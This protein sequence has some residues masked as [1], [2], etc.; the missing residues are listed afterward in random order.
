MQAEALEDAVDLVVGTPQRV[1]QLAERGALYYGDVQYVVLD[2]ADT[3]FD[4]GFGPEVRAVLQPLRKKP[5]PAQAVLVLATLPKVRS[6]DDYAWTLTCN[7]A[8]P[9]TPD[10]SRR[11]HHR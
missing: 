1:S 6:L 3:M 10:S 11:I 4:K 8:F 2:E 5:S 7:P 9:R